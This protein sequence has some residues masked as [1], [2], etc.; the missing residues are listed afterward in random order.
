MKHN[1]PDTFV[2]WQRI[3][4][5][6]ENPTWESQCGFIEQVGF[7]DYI[8]FKGFVGPERTP[9]WESP[10]ATSED[11]RRCLTMTSF[12]HLKQ[13]VERHFEYTRQLTFE[14]EGE[15]TRS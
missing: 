9:L 6:G 5:P 10:L 15:E 7:G 4:E 12:T 14:Y 3:E 11:E 2:Q 13:L 1:D 8:A